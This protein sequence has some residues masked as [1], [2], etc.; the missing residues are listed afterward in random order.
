MS[1]ALCELGNTV[2]MPSLCHPWAKAPQR[3]LAPCRTSPPPVGEEP[4]L[5]R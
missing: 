5:Q 2:T 4:P 3:P 1:G